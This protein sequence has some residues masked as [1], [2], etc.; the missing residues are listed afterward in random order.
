MISDIKVKIQ[1][2]RIKRY[3]V[4]EDELKSSLKKVYNIIWGQCSDQ[5]QATVKFLDDYN[6]KEEEKDIVWLLTQL[7]RETAGID[8]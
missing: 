6:T 2:E 8:S 4:K 1:S 3:V 5:L 7:Q